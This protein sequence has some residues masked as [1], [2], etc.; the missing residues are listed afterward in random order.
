MVSERLRL[1]LKLENTKD[2]N[3]VNNFYVENNVFEEYWKKKN[4]DELV[5]ILCDGLNLLNN[6]RVFVHPCPIDE[7]LNLG[8]SFAGVYKSY[9]PYYC[10]SGHDNITFAIERLLDDRFSYYAEYYYQKNKLIDTRKIDLFI[11]CENEEICGYGTGYVD[12][13]KVIFQYYDSP[14]SIYRKEAKKV[15]GRKDDL[16]YLTNHLQKK[17]MLALFSVQEQI[18][19]IVDVEFVFD[20]NLNIIVNEVRL[21]SDAHRK[22]WNL[23]SEPKW[24][25]GNVKSI[26]LN[27][28]GKIRRRTK[29]WN[30]KIFLENKIDIDNDVLCVNYESDKQLLNIFEQIGDTAGIAIIISYPVYLVDNHFNYIIYEDNSFEFVLRCTNVIFTEGT[31]IQVESDGFNYLIKE[32]M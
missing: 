20:R 7:T 4:S 15:K 30:E 3:L 11:S 27:S 17:I 22:K 26:F 12:S 31:I 25:Y 6:N 5:G 16:L 21:L 32:E 9:K 2:F 18:N 13:K 1:F 23:I 24:I 19:D 8:Y 29:I 28:I 10:L 14:L